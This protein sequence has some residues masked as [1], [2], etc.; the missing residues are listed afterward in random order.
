[1]ADPYVILGVGRNASA[2]EVRDAYRK[3]ALK[4]HPDRNPD[5]T[6]KER[7]QE[8]NAAYESIKNGAKPRP[9][10]A[11][12][13]KP[14]YRTKRTVRDE[15]EK[16]IFTAA[17]PYVR[18]WLMAFAVLCAILLTDLFL[19]ERIHIEN[20]SRVTGYPVPILEMGNGEKISISRDQV[21]PLRQDPRVE[22][23]TTFL[24]GFLRELRPLA[25]GTIGHLGSVFGNFAFAPVIWLVL[26]FA[27][28]M[29]RTPSSTR[30]YIAVVQ[31][32]LTLIFL[33]LFVGSIW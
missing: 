27:G 15:S 8:I 13:P 33:P 7:F 4:F 12:R 11:P 9:V 25:G 30:F 29:V 28:M 32:L 14:Y 24:F 21:L 3:L 17:A 10:I 16:K 26:A 23:H 1:M 19:P 20:A 2:R 31:V 5:P 18:W 6:A 22:V